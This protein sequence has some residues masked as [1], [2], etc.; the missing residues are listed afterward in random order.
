MPELSDYESAILSAF[1]EAGPTMP[2]AMGDVPLSWL[3]VD[4]YARQ[5]SAISDP[6]EARALVYMS[7]A[8]LEGRA[9]GANPLAIPPMEREENDP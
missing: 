4:A 1:S 7:G 5:T 2:G 6:W 9:H 3:E 8:Y